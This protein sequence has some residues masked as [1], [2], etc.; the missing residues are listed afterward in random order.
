MNTL[1]LAMITK[2]EAEKLRRCLES[3]KDYVDEIVVVDTG[4]EDNSIE[5]A[6]EFTDKVYTFEWIGDF[7]AARNFSIEKVDSDYVL[8]LDSDEWIESIDLEKLRNMLE[9]NVLGKVLR[10]DYLSDINKTDGYSAIKIIRVFP[11]SERYIGKIHEQVNS[12]FREIELPL[13]LGH[14][15]YV[16]REKNKSKRN[17]DLLI[18]E[19]KRDKTNPYYNYQLGK[20][21]E[22]LKDYKNASKYFGIAYK[23]ANRRA[24][25]FPDFVC[26]YILCLK[27]SGSV[28][29]GLRII[30]NERNRFNDYPNFLFNSALLYMELII[31]NIQKYIG[32]LGLIE[33]NYLTCIEIGETYKYTGV[34]GMGSYMAMHNLG[35]FYE[36]LGKTENAVKY[37]KM[38]AEYD[39]EPAIKRLEALGIVS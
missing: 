2:N 20:E 23:T 15:G 17:M 12:A 24:P 10:N 9:G 11:K 38:A 13:V 6:R 7:S 32:Y 16:N 30:E 29:E 26:D 37:Y 19:L 33:T 34:Y 31:S 25:Y 8:V 22:F 1:A 21:Y 14:D 36:T 18:A 3:V 5:V 4:S 35:V 28:E 27:N 39:Y